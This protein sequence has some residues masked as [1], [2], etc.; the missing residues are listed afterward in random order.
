MH[1]LLMTLQQAGLI[2]K[3]PVFADKLVINGQY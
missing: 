3:Q 1:V 2:N